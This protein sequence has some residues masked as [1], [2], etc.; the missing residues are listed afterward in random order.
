MGF[1]H[2][3]C[4]SSEVVAHQISAMRGR[5]HAVSLFDTAAWKNRPYRVKK[6]PA[7][8]LKAQSL[9]SSHF[10]CRDDQVF[11][12]FT[13]NIP[14][15]DHFFFHWHKQVVKVTTWYIYSYNR[16]TFLLSEVHPT[17]TTMTIESVESTSFRVLVFCALMWCY[18]QMRTIAMQSF[19]TLIVYWFYFDI[20]IS[21]LR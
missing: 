16:T 14:K 15:N 13:R 18:T 5:R 6:E 3:S 11:G 1:T 17:I 9:S 2:S 7:V 4:A 12:L 19:V 8:L 10:L 20:T 21:D